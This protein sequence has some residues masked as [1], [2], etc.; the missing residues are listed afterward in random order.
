MYK[1]SFSL[2]YTTPEHSTG[3][4]INLRL[5]R[6]VQSSA[7]V[8]GSMPAVASLPPPTASYLHRMPGWRRVCS[9][10]KDEQRFGARDGYYTPLNWFFGN[11]KTAAT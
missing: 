4:R 7:R 11:L 9:E 6:L 5:A 1:Q 8:D 2:D 10:A 3:S